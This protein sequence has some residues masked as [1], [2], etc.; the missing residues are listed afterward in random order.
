MCYNLG[1]SDER[2]IIMTFEKKFE[3]LKKSLIKAD[4]K[5]FTEGFAFQVNITDEDCAGAFYIAFVNGEYSV[6]PYDYK[7]RTAL[8]TGAAADIAK[9]AKGTVAVSVEGNVGQVE[10]YAASFKKPAVKKAPAKKP[11]AKKAEP[12]K[13]EAPAKKVEEAPKAEPVKK[14]VAEKKVAE[15]KKPAVAKAAAK[16]AAPAAKPAEKTEMK[17]TKT[18]AVKT[19]AAKTT[20]KKK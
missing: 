15:V 16:T 9:L 17:T 8:L 4:T 2:V 14:A 5:K 7:D 13:K 19:A 3:T 6:E 20:E 18:P 11:A 10:M 12:A 1:K